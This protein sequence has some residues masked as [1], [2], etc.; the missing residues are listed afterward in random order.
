MRTDSNIPRKANKILNLILLAFLL[1]LL[2]VWYLGFVQQEHHHQQARKP[3]RRSIVQKVE[4][5][6]IRD[7]FNIPLSQN[8]IGYTASIR[9]A[10]LRDIPAHRWEKSEKGGKVKVPVRG[11]YISS[12]AEILSKELKMDPQGIEDIVYAKASLFPHTPFIIKENLTEQE[13]YRIRML[14]KDWRGIEA[15][16]V[17]RRVYPF[18]KTAC[19]I[20]G[21]M[22]AINPNEYLHIAEEIKT[23]QEYVK[24]RELGEIVFLPPGYD[25][26]LEVRSRLQA[27]KEKAYTINDQVGKAGIEGFCDEILRGVHGKSMYE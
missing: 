8:K 4:R 14:Q 17:S 27:L 24:K 7:R 9:Y 16:R 13:Y 26:P 22:G 10:D 18:H 2:R 20:V 1:I 12:L 5:A 25:N 11:P 6:T 21:Y 3:K 23:L 15:E 19:D